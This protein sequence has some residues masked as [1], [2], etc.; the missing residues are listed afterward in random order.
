MEG[1]GTR[2]HLSTLFT[3]FLREHCPPGGRNAE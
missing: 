1:E 2:E 3:N